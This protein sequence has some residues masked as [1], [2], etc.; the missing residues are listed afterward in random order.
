VGAMS[1]MFW[2][3]AACNISPRKTAS[4]KGR[5]ASGV[6]RGVQPESDPRMLPGSDHAD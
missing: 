4:P 3:N 5:F 1:T 6:C 2:F